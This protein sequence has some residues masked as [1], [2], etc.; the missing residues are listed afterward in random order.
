MCACTCAWAC[1]CVRVCVCMRACMCVCV[2][3][4]VWVCACMHMRV[5]VRV[6]VRV[7]VHVFAC[8]CVCVR[9]LHTK[10]YL[11]SKV[12]AMVMLHS[13]ITVAPTFENFCQ[14][15]GRQNLVK[16][17]QRFSRSQKFQ[18][19][20]LQSFNIVKRVA[21]WLLRISAN[22]IKSKK[23]VRCRLK[24]SKVKFV[25][26]LYSQLSSELTF[27]NFCHSHKRQK[28]VGCRLKFSKNQIYRDLI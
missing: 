12:S 1:A 18:K 16:C 24:F 13:K 23:L 4:D 25:V 2:F 22:H 11:F 26:N 14:S 28:L 20:D 27:E 19:S 21:S 9:I 7:H 10:W 15:Y 8:M 3:V 6:R 5:R 17:R